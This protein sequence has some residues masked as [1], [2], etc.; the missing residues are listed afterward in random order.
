MTD[1]K[2]TTDF[3]RRWN[4]RQ[5]DAGVL[6][7]EV[8]AELVRL[9]TRQIQEDAELKVDGLAGPATRAE[10]EDRLGLNQRGSKPPRKSRRRPPPDLVPI[11]TRRNIEAVYG[12]FGYAE[13][14][15]RPGAIILDKK[16]VRENI[17]KCHF[18]PNNTQ[19][20]WCHR[21]VAEEFPRLL[22]KA[23]ELSGYYPK[24]VWSWVPRYQ[25]WDPSR[26]RLSDHSWGIAF[27]LDP[28]LNKAGLTGGTPLHSAEGELFVSVFM[29]AG[30]DCG[31]NWKSYPDPMH[32]S[33]VR[34]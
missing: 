6:E 22:K 19:Y 10:I 8:L 14:P 4:E 17:V 15:K 13:D 23:S 1:E 12:S 32:F 9:G 28:H 18:G 27:D 7:G 34:G 33:R 20:T 5:V 26:G 31:I 24:K 25:R 21:L 16:W 11:P 3:E 2:R 29:D 30:W